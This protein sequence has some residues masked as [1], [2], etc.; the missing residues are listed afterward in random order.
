MLAGGSEVIHRLANVWTRYTDYFSD[1][2]D[3][4]RKNLLKKN[5]S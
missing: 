2:A 1:R 3:Q 4:Q 5:P